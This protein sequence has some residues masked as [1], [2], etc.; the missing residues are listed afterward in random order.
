MSKARE[1]L[2]EAAMQCDKSYAFEQ[3]KDINEVSTLAK[4]IRRGEYNDGAL[5][6]QLLRP[7]FD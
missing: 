4:R 6:K 3:S 5:K 7:D 2:R 1:K